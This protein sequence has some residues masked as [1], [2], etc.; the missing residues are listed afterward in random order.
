[1]ATIS[2]NLFWSLI[3]SVLQLYT[4]SIV[5]IALAKLMAVE[6]FG[7]LSFGFSLSALAVI[8]ADFGFSLMV[9]KDYP[10]QGDQSGKYLANSLLSKMVLAAVSGIFFYIYLLLFYNGQWLQV[11]G[12]Y[13]V[14]AV[15]ASFTI[16]LQS[17]LKVQNRFNKYTES[18]LVYALAVTISVVLYWH[19]KLS[20]LQLVLCLLAAKAMQLLWTTV[21]C[22]FDFIKFS[23]DGKL[24]GKLLKNSWS[25]GVFG[26]LGIFYF[27]V[28]TQII[29]V[30]LGAKEVALYQAV[31]RIILILMVFSDIMSNVLLP[32]LS[33]KFFNKENVGELV[34]KLFLYLLIIGCSLFLAFTSFKT[35]VL[36]LLYTQEYQEAAA[37][38]LPFSIVVI[39]RTVSTLLGNILTISNKQVYRV[40]TVSVSLFVSLLLNLICIPKYGILAAAWISVLVHL[41]LFGMYFA[42]SRIEVPSIELHSLSNL[43]LVAVTIII[44]GMIHHV[45]SGGLWIVLGCA[46]L[47]LLTVFGIMRQ[48]NNLDFLKQVLREKG[49]G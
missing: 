2:K 25:F 33:F 11:G 49:V 19:L 12:L 48:G 37:L 1:M 47:W 26:I 8:V 44:Y 17:L 41:I 40:I 3:T 36:T 46:A 6:D 28:D 14:F 27:M 20:L 23:Y 10:K 15:V 35:E 43:F 16:Y 24:M 45:T 32:Y 9:I 30:Y 42:Y 5:F 31:F 39:L 29:S 13:L 21:L 22:K 34:S 7:I 38:V 18:N 4:G